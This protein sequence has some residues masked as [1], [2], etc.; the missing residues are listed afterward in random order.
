LVAQ[1]VNAVLPKTVTETVQHRLTVCLS[2]ERIV[3]AVR[4][5][6]VEELAK[7]RAEEWPALEQ[8]AKR[9]VEVITPRLVEEAGTRLLR[10]SLH[11]GLEQHV[12]AAVRGYMTNADALIKQEVQEAVARCLP[13]MAE[14]MVRKT[15]LERVTDAVER[16]VPDI[17][18]TQVKAELRRLTAPE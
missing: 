8:A 11:A 4:G 1:E 12:P 5:P 14:D 15:A 2:D 13:R 7:Q 17:A 16:I 10:D 18:E 6:L 9:Q 3:S